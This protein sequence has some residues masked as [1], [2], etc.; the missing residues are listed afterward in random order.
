LGNLVYRSARNWGRRRQQRQDRPL[1]QCGIEG[2][3]RGG[4]IRKIC[5]A[6]AQETP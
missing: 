3:V 2:V 6:G 4:W 1:S 5:R